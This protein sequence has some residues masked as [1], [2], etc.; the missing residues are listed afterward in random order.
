MNHARGRME[1][2]VRSWANDDRAL[3]VAIVAGITGA[4][5]ETWAQVLLQRE[6]AG[7]PI[8]DDAANQAL[9]EEISSEGFTET[10]SD[11]SEMA[12]G[13]ARFMGGANVDPQDSRQNDTFN[14]RGN[15][16]AFM[17]ETMQ[18]ANRSP[19][20]MLADNRVGQ[21]TGVRGLVQAFG[22]VAHAGADLAPSI[23]RAGAEA[24]RKE[25]FSWDMVGEFFDE[26]LGPL[27]GGV[28]DDVIGHPALYGHLSDTFSG[29][30]VGRDP[31][32]FVYKSNI[33]PVQQAELDRAA[34]DV[35]M[36]ADEQYAM[37]D[38][39][40][41]AYAANNRYSD[42]YSN[43]LK[44]ET[45]RTNLAWSA[46]QANPEVQQFQKDYGRPISQQSTSDMEG[47]TASFPQIIGGDGRPH[48][49]RMS[50]GRFVAALVTEPGSSANRL[51]S[52]MVDAPLSVTTDPL[53]FA[54]AP[55]KLIKA[56]RLVGITEE[57]V[58]R[59]GRIAA[60][61]DVVKAVREAPSAY[62][63]DPILDLR[64]S[65]GQGLEQSSI[66]LGELVTQVRGAASEMD[67]IS[68]VHRAR[69]TVE[70]AGASR[71]LTGGQAQPV[72]TALMKTKT[73]K[74]V[75]T[76]LSGVK[77][78]IP[79]SLRLQLVE[80]LTEG[81]IIDALL[82]HINQGLR[83][84]G[85][86]RYWS[87]LA[88]YGSLSEYFLGEGLP[89][90]GARTLGLGA[91]GP[92]N[93]IDRTVEAGLD[94]LY[95]RGIVGGISSEVI[96]G[97]NMRA[98]FRSQYGNAWLGRMANDASNKGIRADDIDAGYSQVEDLARNAGVNTDD[99]WAST[100]KGKYIV[101]KTMK[102]LED[103]LDKGEKLV[104]VVNL[105]DAMRDVA[106]LGPHDQPGMFAAVAK[107]LDGAAI[108]MRSEGIDEG[109]IKQATRLYEEVQEEALYMVNAIGDTVNYPGSG[110]ASLVDDEM[111]LLAGPQLINELHKGIVNVPDP[112]ITRRALAEAHLPG[113]LMNSLTTKKTLDFDIPIK[114]LG[115]KGGLTGIEKTWQSKS[116]ADRGLIRFQRS[117]LNNWW[118]PAKL[119]RMGYVI[120]IPLGDEQARMAA[121][122][123][124]SFWAP[125]RIS[126]G[127]SLL[128]YFAYAFGKRADLDVL[129]NE[130]AAARSFKETVSLQ[131]NSY[132][133]VGAMRS[134]SWVK[135]YRGS[136]DFADAITTEIAQLIDD[137]LLG[138]M[139]GPEVVGDPMVHAKNWLLANPEGQ[140]ILEVLYK[141]VR[142]VSPEVADDFRRGGQALDNYIAGVFARA[143]LKTGGDY[144]FANAVTGEV[145]D[146]ADNVIG[147][148]GQGEFATT[149]PGFTVTRA[150]RTDLTDMFH[151]KQLDGKN[152][153][154]MNRAE[155]NSLRQQIATKID[156]TPDI[157]PQ[158]A[159]I[160]NPDL[161]NVTAPKLARR[162]VNTIMDWTVSRSAKRFSRI[163]TYEQLYWRT[164][165]TYLPDVTDD[166]AELLLKAADDTGMKRV[167]QTQA[168]K[169]GRGTGAKI[170]SLDDINLYAHSIATEGII[171]LLFDFAKRKN[172]FDALSL[173]NP[174]GDAFLEGVVNYSRIF[175]NNPAIIRRPMQALDSL[176]ET[177]PFADGKEEFDP[178]S[179]GFFHTNRFGEEIF[180]LSIGTAGGALPF[181]VEYEMNVD[182]LNMIANQFY[183]GFGQVVSIPAAGLPDTPIWQG[184]K[185]FISPFGAGDTPFEELQK[186]TVGASPTLTRILTAMGA[187]EYVDPDQER[188]FQKRKAWAF[189]E[190]LASGE[191]TVEDL[192]DPDRNQEIQAIIGDRAATTTFLEGFLRFTAPAGGRLSLYV[193]LDDPAGHEKLAMQDAATMYYDIFEETGD[194][195]MATEIFNDRFGYDPLPFLVTQT[196]NKNPSGVTED[197]WGF[198]TTFPEVWDV[199]PRTAYFLVPDDPEDPFFYKAWSGDFDSGDR[200][201]LSIQEQVDDY[202]Y[203]FAAREYGHRTQQLRDDVAQ[204]KVTLP[205][206]LDEEDFFAIA[207]D[208]IQNSIV[209]RLPGYEAKVNLFSEEE[210]QRDIAELK[211]WSDYDRLSDDPTAQAVE[212][213]FGQWES[214]KV[215]Q[216]KAGAGTKSVNVLPFMKANVLPTNSRG[217]SESWLI[218]EA[219]NTYLLDF[220]D[221]LALDPDSGSFAVVWERIIRPTIYDYRRDVQPEPTEDPGPITTVDEYIERMLP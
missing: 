135:A 184:L 149:A 29:K 4:S 180:S 27:V 207:N 196:S 104:E 83:V 41:E 164:I 127:D 91:A 159:K 8:T 113:R 20:R 107:V 139:F 169:A 173:I 30:T 69:K 133:E 195:E 55:G 174:F 46:G 206:G 167:V 157:F 136:D 9:A 183:P 146:S 148:L 39:D 126:E 1:R 121:T 92:W 130:M 192:A 150:G 45:G 125:G 166:V 123:L 43:V 10:P 3:A 65:V 201:Q 105:D 162:V 189:R 35:S 17:E 198:E 79:A 117:M 197:A 13:S 114:E 140:K 204:G 109:F 38:A 160:A 119:F 129:G 175:V 100:N 218:R 200:Q 137:P 208:E 42:P 57:G 48:L 21:N 7:V 120:K 26:A 205:D 124:S 97:V 11:V 122:G 33:S 211:T 178:E 181:P 220:G 112:R 25:G 51:L 66:E 71:W 194:W 89:S 177:N 111:E 217:V 161:M 84:Q 77:G 78:R 2:F 93:L 72:V 94:A 101:A 168:A 187:G 59:A 185:N 203:R 141:A 23:W 24:K 14:L 202:V 165:G 76:I 103:Q 60:T 182:S 132:G 18:W 95:N 63:L 108:K 215:S 73:M 81:E 62:S 12:P 221:M 19:G 34:Q 179:E 212:E 54:A 61:P 216:L 5:D 138:K 98:R 199:L 210:A 209:M 176:R 156:E 128:A 158:A 142:R 56:R 86:M 90:A 219:V 58:E 6:Q 28:E 15:P 144:I 106:R 147:R 153:E 22:L 37:F 52:G 163:P 82:P 31:N 70:P 68:L 16:L 47:F 155:Y 213:F 115:L 74:E 214:S 44:Y 193:G 96:G 154:R 190:G 145:L 67:A 171:D 49:T 191:W 36:Y 40:P 102:E 110:F 134:D 99:I 188:A 88:T 143:H 172:V 85:N 186:Q 53:T 50:G 152:V 87:E 170:S 116:L 75:S 118:K 80:G 131:G 64:K 151:T 32:S